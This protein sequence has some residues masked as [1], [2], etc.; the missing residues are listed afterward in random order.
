M[1]QFQVFSVFMRCTCT[2]QN[3]SSMDYAMPNCKDFS[4]PTHAVNCLWQ[5]VTIISGA[6]TTLVIVNSFERNSFAGTIQDGNT[7]IVKL[8]C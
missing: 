3:C 4:H 6:P 2:T 7:N 5:D 8:S 1:G